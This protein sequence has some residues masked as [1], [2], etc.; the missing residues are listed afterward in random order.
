MKTHPLILGLAALLTI[1]FCTPALGATPLL[2]EVGVDYLAGDA[3]YSVAIGDLNGDGKPDLAVASLLSVTSVL[4]G[5]GDG[6]FQAAVNYG[7]DSDVPCGLHVLFPQ[8][9]PHEL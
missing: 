2:F 6:T 1:C 5:N 9:D 7:A 4:L 8:E 3:P